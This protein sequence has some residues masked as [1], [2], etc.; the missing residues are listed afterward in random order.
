MVLKLGEILKDVNVDQD[1]ELNQI[2]EISKLNEIEEISE[3]DSDT[4]ES[5]G[6]DATYNADNY[7]S[8]DLH[9]DDE[10]EEQDELDD[11][12][13]E[14][15]GSPPPDEQPLTDIEPFT[16]REKDNAAYAN[17]VDAYY[18]DKNYTLAIEKFQTAIENEKQNN[19]AVPNELIAKS[20]YWQAESYVKTEDLPAAIKVL[21]SLIELF[22]KG[23]NEHYLVVAAE[24]RVEHLK[25]RES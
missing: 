16:P 6:T 1:D 7:E 5:L 13:E 25:A 11:L 24:R 14:Q 19:E 9:E 12:D 10:D 15:F 4:S 2:E 8:D 18:I 21:E 20:M 22:T 3:D 23:Y 17:A